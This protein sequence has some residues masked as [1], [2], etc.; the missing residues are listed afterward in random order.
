[1][2]SSGSDLSPNL[3]VGRLNS[4]YAQIIAVG[5]DL[6]D[7]EALNDMFVPL[8]NDEDQDALTDLFA[9]SWFSRV[10]TFQEIICAAEATVTSGSLCLDFAYIDRFCVLWSLSR[11][12]IWLKTNAAQLAVGQI[13]ALWITK[14]H[15]S[16]QSADNSL[17]KLVKRTRT[18]QSTDPRDHIYDLVALASDMNP[19]PFAPKYEIG[20]N[21]LYEAFAAHVIRQK[22]SVDIFECCIFQP[23]PRQCPSW[24]P[25]WRRSEGFTLPIDSESETFRAAGASCWD[26]STEIV[27][28]ELVVEA[29]CLDNLQN[30]I[31]PGP[32]PNTLEVTHWESDMLPLLKWQ[33]IMIKETTEM[34]SL[35]LL[36]KPEQERWHTWWRTIIQERKTRIKRATPDYEQFISS[37]KFI[38]NNNINNNPN[39]SSR[40]LGQKPF[41]VIYACVIRMAMYRRFCL[42][43]EGRI[44]WVPDA[45]RAGSL[46]RGSLVPVLIRPCRQENSYLV[47]GQCYIYG[48]MDGECR[49]REGRSIL[50]NRAGVRSYIQ[51]AIYVVRVD[52]S[53][54]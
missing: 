10:W 25:D 43:R 15:L 24:A 39:D 1:M 48:I 40:S 36:Y 46:M 6:D 32:F 50:I 47:I 53:K 41:T 28:H 37:Y 51:H 7:R 23:D 13:A 12:S 44:G 42:S 33:Q 9:K 11:Q 20:V 22:G 31:S 26:T 30:I 19:V 38:I 8:R 17:L 29:V 45:A 21:Q 35:S 3:I 2:Y 4:F 5:A 16:Q 18:R 27:N 34:T 54:V 14:E 49:C 52:G